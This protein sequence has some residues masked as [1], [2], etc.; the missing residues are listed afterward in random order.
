MREVLQDLRHAIRLLTKRPGFTLMAVLP[1]ALGIGANTAMFSVVNGVL[2]RPL[3]FRDPER[4]VS[5]HEKTTEFSSMALSYPNLQDWKAQNRSFEVLCGFRSDE[6]TLTGS[7]DTQRITMR[8]VSAPYFEMLGINLRLGRGFLP[9]EDRPGANPVIILSEEFWRD[10]LGGD[11]GVIGRSLVLDGQSRTVV[12]IAPAELRLYGLQQAYTPL[13]QW[14]DPMLNQRDMHPGIGAIARMKPGIT[15]EQ[16]RSD[17]AGVARRLAE[18][19]PHDNSG[20]AITITPL[21]TSIV[22]DV[23]PALWVLTGAVAFV[24]LIACVNVANL[25]L[26]RASAREREIA[27]R[28]SLGASRGRLIRQLLTESVLLSLI[29]GL[30]GL[31]IAVWS[32]AAI[33]KLLGRILPA[34]L[35][36]AHDIVVDRNVLLFTLAGSLVT[37]MLFGIAPAIQATH[38]RLHAIMKE[39]GRSL[40]GGGR[41]LR[42]GLVVA[43]VA[44]AL[45]LLAG[46]GLMI[47]SL[48]ELA[49]VNPGFDAHNVLTFNVSIAQKNLTDPA[50]SRLEIAQ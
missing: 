28:A 40:I 7:G 35:P 17:M 43:E 49:A 37:G 13:G 22:G 26:A 20:H 48:K 47:R 25:L 8:M 15:V 38:G 6:A 19:Y 36:R 45:V 2:L 44:L 27:I 1:L 3:P 42:D 9:E 39:G 33:V 34:A 4:L 32:T 18:A 41:R 24:L 11:P 30:A 29:G 10:H 5:M 23:R 21:K 50:S 12:G 14:T 46:A 31:G 16:A